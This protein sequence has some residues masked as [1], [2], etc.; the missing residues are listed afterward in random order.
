MPLSSARL[1]QS[2]NFCT[3]SSFKVPV[4][5]FI[6]VNSGNEKWYLVRHTSTRTI[7]LAMSLN[8][9][10]PNSTKQLHCWRVMEAVSSGD[11]RTC[12]VCGQNAAG[13]TGISTSAIQEFDVAN[14]TVKTISGKT[15]LLI[16]LPDNSRLGD[17]AWQKWCKDNGIAAQR[18]VTNDYVKVDPAPGITFKKVGNR[19]VS[20]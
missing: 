10:P 12:H 8:T 20:L 4:Y 2:S 19:P 7:D 15:Y 11:V 3:S 14:M 16:G 6:F 1:H 13:D 17:G 18:D 9:I 5:L